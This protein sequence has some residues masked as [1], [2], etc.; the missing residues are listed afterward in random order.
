MCDVR[1]TRRHRGSASSTSHIADRTSHIGFTLVELLVVVAIIA[2]LI[3][4]LLPSLNKAREAGRSVVCM[5]HL[6][7]IGQA[8]IMYAGEN[9]Q[10][11]PYGCAS[12]PDGGWLSF[13][14]LLNPYLGGTLDLDKQ[15]T[16][17]YLKGNAEKIFLCPSDRLPPKWNVRRSYSLCRNYDRGVAYA[18]F[19]GDLPLVKTV[20]LSEIAG[21]SET[22]QASELSS[23]FNNLGNGSN[24][25]L[26]KAEQ[27]MADYTFEVGNIY[28]TEFLHNGP[29]N[30]LMVDGHVE[31]NTPEKTVG[32]GNTTN[33]LGIWTRALGD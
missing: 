13:D 6:K 19:T 14:D 17:H 21:P 1:Q 25:V 30:Y 28:G 2:L 26:D 8:V 10:T 22:M 33:S 4:I 16:N 7:Q 15:R 32:S 31:M 27:Q 24:G 18:D 9:N 29:V 12:F 5:T 20:R 11:L 23:I 3:A